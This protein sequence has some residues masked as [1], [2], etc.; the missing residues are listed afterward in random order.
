M[1]PFDDHRQFVGGL[2]DGLLDGS[3]SRQFRRFRRPVLGKEG[4]EPVGQRL[5][6]FVQQSFERPRVGRRLPVM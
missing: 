5:L 2:A 3:T 4:Q 1:Q 6:H